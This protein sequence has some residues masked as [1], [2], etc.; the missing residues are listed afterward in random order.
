LLRDRIVGAVKTLNLSTTGKEAAHASGTI[1]ACV[2][3][4]RCGG[5]R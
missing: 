2:N 1:A 3:I 4:L 5:Y